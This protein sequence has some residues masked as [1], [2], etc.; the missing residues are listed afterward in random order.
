MDLP[1]DDSG[2]AA[3]LLL[4]GPIAF[5]LFAPYSEGLFLLLSALLFMMARRS[6][7][8]MAAVAGGLAALT[9]QQG[10]FLALPLMWELWEWCGRDISKVLR[11]WR[12]V[13]S[14][15]LVPAGL[16]GWLVYRGFMFSDI[17]FDVG[18][19]RTWVYG[20]L[21][22]KDA[23]Q[24]VEEQRFDLPWNALADALR[25][26][27]TSTVFDLVLGAVFVAM[28]AAGARSLWRMRK[29]YVLYAAVILLVSFSYNTGAF[30]PYMGL[31]RHCLLAFPLFLPMAVWAR[32]PRVETVLLGV[33]FLGMAVLTFSYAAKI[34][35]V[36]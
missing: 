17:V 29:S 27:Q 1:P 14:V 12:S 8:W 24:V 22:S 7:W 28:F 30:L 16:L 35:W 25:S 18:N 21:I 34:F 2:R 15:L 9:R 19:P 31:P 26:L 23:S 3:R 11:R 32:R 13:V 4:H 6:R 10:I 5:I 33:G 20:L 36:P